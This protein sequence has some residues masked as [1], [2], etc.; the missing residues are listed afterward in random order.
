MVDESKRFLDREKFH[1]YFY[2]E[3][4][5]KYARLPVIAVRVIKSCPMKIVVGCATASSESGN[6]LVNSDHTAGLILYL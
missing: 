5:F 2:S 3:H 4:V 6:E 1:Q